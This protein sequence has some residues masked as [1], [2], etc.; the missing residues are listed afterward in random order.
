MVP[1]VLEKGSVVLPVW[2]GVNGGPAVL[3]V[4]LEA[5]HAATE[6]GSRLPIGLYA[7]TLVAQ[8]T[9]KHVGLNLYL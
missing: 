9:I 4:V 7:M 2:H 6:K 3:T 1:D 5:G 8:L